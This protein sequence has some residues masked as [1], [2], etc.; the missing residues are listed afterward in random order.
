MFKGIDVDKDGVIDKDEL[1]DVMIKLGQ[2][3]ITDNELAQMISEI[4]L[5]NNQKIEFSE[6]LTVHN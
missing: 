5:N 4:D 6:Y 2:T 3:E 1:K